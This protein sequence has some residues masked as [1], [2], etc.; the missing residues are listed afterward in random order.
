MSQLARMFVVLNFLLAAGFL[1]AAAM[2]LGINHE[3]KK[4]HDTMN[5]D[6][7]QAR[8]DA[9]K[10]EKDLQTR[11]EELTRESS[12]LKEDNAGTKATAARLTEAN[13]TAEKDKKTKEAD[14]TKEQANLASA[15]ENLKRANE[16]LT[17]RTEEANKLRT[18]AATAQAAERK[19]NEELEKAKTEIR[20][21]DNSIA[22]LEKGKTD[23]TG[24]I[25]ELEIIKK[26]AQDAK[27]DLSNIVN[28]APIPDAKVIGWDP[29]MK[30]VQVNAGTAQKVAR[31]TTLDIVRGSSYIG[32]IKID[33]VYPNSAA[34]TLYIAAPGQTVQVGDR[35]T[36]TI[37]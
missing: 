21:R 5:K 3:W 9:R 36:N 20:N 1:Y 19:A 14:F 27:V 29:D 2:F 37:N 16:E 24:K 11:V 10:R 34:G 25:E 15:N 22:E 23:M 30:L 4:K 8:E 31:G 32:R 12:T 6:L 33:Q 35:A 17:K 28:A 7:T 26:I 18:D 13:A